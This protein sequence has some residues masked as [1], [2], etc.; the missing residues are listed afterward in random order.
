MQPNSLRA[1]LTAALAESE[2][3]K[4]PVVVATNKRHDEVADMLRE[5]TLARRELLNFVYFTGEKRWHYWAHTHGGKLNNWQIRVIK[6]E[7]SNG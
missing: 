6:E 2:E 5:I 7:Q 1:K 3:S 4:Q